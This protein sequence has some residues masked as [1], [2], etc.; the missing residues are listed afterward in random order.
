MSQGGRDRDSRR[1]RKYEAALQPHL[2]AIIH[3]ALNHGHLAAYQNAW[4]VYNMMADAFG[5]EETDFDEWMH[6]WVPWLR[7]AIRN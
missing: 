6:E 1:K 7:Q 5:D 3:V 2:F 4:F